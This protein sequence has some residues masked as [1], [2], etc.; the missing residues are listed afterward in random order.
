MSALH[1]GFLVSLS[2]KQWKQLFLF[3]CFIDVLN[4]CPLVSLRTQHWRYNIHSISVQAQIFQHHNTFASDAASSFPTI[5]YS[6]CPDINT[7]NRVSEDHHPGRNFPKC[8]F[9]VIL[10]ILLVCTEAKTL[11]NTG[12][13]TKWPKRQQGKTLMVLTAVFLELW[14]QL[15][16]LLQVLVF[17]SFLST[18]GCLSF[19]AQDNVWR[20]EIWFLRGEHDFV[21]SKIVWEP[22]PGPTFRKLEA[23]RAQSLMWTVKQETSCFRSETCEMKKYLYSYILEFLMREKE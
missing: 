7:E 5:S 11:R 6:A 21:K 20:L 16:S 18:L 19:T 3:N 4:Q 23:S 15:F 14:T 22:N 2:A 1:K 12:S 17:C 10:K 8:Q 9:S 13:G